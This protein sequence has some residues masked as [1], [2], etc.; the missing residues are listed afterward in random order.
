MANFEAFTTKWIVSEDRVVRC[1]A[2]KIDRALTFYDFP[3]Q[4]WSK[5]RTNNVAE[6]EAS[7]SSGNGSGRSGRS[8]TKNRQREL[9]ER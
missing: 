4:D 1:L 9:S 5:I 6:R 7:A 8:P 3:Q 2:D